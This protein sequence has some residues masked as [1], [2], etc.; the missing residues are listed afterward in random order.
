MIKSRFY[1]YKV[2][3][4]GKYVCSFCG[5]LTNYYESTSKKSYRDAGR[6]MLSK[7]NKDLPE[8]ILK[9]PLCITVL[10]DIGYPIYLKNPQGEQLK[11]IKNSL[12]KFIQDNKLN[13][14]LEVAA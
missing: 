3:N 5:P 4:E 12:D 1:I 7:L 11:S 9:N 2:S 8:E 14:K 6:K 10:K 13:I